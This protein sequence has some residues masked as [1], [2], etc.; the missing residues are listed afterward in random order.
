MDP[1]R[2]DS[3]TR[4]LATGVSR[5]R[6]VAGLTAAVFG[7]VDAPS[8]AAA[9]RG[10]GRSCREG[11]NCCSGVCR[12]DETGRSRC[13]PVGTIACGP[14]CID[15]KSDR[16]NCGS[17]GIVCPSAACTT[18]IACVN[19]ECQSAPIVCQAVDDPAG[20]WNQPTCDPSTGNCSQATPKPSGT[21]CD[22]G[23][24]CAT[25][26]CDGAGTCNSVPKNC[27]LV[28]GSCP[29]KCD[30][31][32]G[33]CVAG[34]NGDACTPSSIEQCRTGGVCQDGG[35]VAVLSPVGSPCFVLTDNPCVTGICDSN[36]TCG[37]TNV[38]DETA[39]TP[40]GPV[41]ECQTAGVCRNGSCVAANSP[42]GTA[43]GTSVFEC[44]RKV[45]QS[46][47][48]VTEKREGQRCEIDFHGCMQYTCQDGSCNYSGKDDACPV[49]TGCGA[50]ICAHDQPF[51]GVG[52]C[53]ANDLVECERLDGQLICLPANRVCEGV[54]YAD[55]I[56]CCG[57]SSLAG[58][59]ST[60]SADKLCCTGAFGFMCCET[61]QTCGLLGCGT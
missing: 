15:T 47:A 8:V 3:F 26:T 31:A 56:T 13:C 39:C 17:C 59:P 55:P 16:N 49:G 22:G 37:L 9:C 44:T 38:A 2:F 5:R 11:A 14:T 10:G 4:A 24:L 33:A 53:V 28:I 57:W 29:Q 6:L 21:P 46:G 1:T 40:T 45:C 20:C 43:C 25:S 51:P 60:C 27:G 32:T 52:T 36:G 18:D 7:L 41:G 19:G 61:W 54:C 42:D 58:K 35:C 48:C 23:D 12:K 34:E 50:G 30:P